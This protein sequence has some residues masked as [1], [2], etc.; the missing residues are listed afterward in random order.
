MYYISTHFSTHDTRKQNP[1][2]M[3]PNPKQNFQLKN[4]SSVLENQ[5]NAW[6]SAF[7]KTS[8]RTE[9]ILS[10]MWCSKNLSLTLSYPLFPIVNLLSTFV[11]SFTILFAR[12]FTP[13][14]PTLCNKPV[15]PFTT[16]SVV[17]PAAVPCWENEK[18]APRTITK[19]VK[20]ENQ[21]WFVVN[22]L[23]VQAA[24]RPL[25]QWLSSQNTLRGPAH[26]YRE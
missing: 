11:A 9:A 20:I 23:P 16:I 22:S 1:K 5:E 7:F 10:D 6:F 21:V 24:E 12:G 25:L 3:T 8:F 13:S 2:P 17:P 14:F 26:E 19:H 4:V 18:P 15:V